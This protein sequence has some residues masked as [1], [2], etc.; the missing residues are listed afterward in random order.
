[1]PH[2][3]WASKKIGDIPVANLGLILAL[4]II[5]PLV[6]PSNYWIRIAGNAGLW[7]MLALGLNVVAGF[8][9]LLDLGYVA[10]YAVGGYLYALLSSGHWNIH[11]PFLLVLPICGLVASGF[12]WAL[13][14]TSMRVRGDYLA[15]VTLA[16][17]QIMRLLLL[18]LDRPVNITGGPNGLVDLDYA[19][20][21]GF[22]FRTVTQ[23]YYLIISM[24]LLVV[25]ASYRLKRSRLG[26]GW[27]AIR[28]DE[29]AANAMGVNVTYMKLLAFGIGAGIAGGA[30]AVFASWQGGV[31]PNNFD[32][33]QLVT[34]YCM[35]ILGGVGNIWGVILA[36][37]ILSILP[38]AL[39][40]YGAYRMI[41]YGLLLVILMAV[42]PQGLLGEIT[43]FS[44]RRK[45]EKGEEVGELKSAEELFYGEGSR[46]FVKP[47][48]KGGLDRDRVLL[49]LKDLTMDFGGLRAV[50]ML[51]LEVR[52]GEIVSIIGPNGAG[53]TTV[54]NLITGIY[55]PTS[56]A[57]LFEGEDITGKK[58]HQI[59]RMGIGRTFQ[60]LRLFN[61][62]TVLENAMV[63]QHCRSSSS[64][65]SVL[66]RTPGFLREEERIERIAKENLGLFGARLTGFRYNQKAMNLSYANRRRMEMARALSTDSKLVLLDEPSA[67]MNPKETEEITRFIRQ[68]RDDYGCS[69]L[70]IEHKLKVVKTISDRVIVL[71][72]GSKIA[73]GEYDDVA[74]NE[75]VIQ[76]YLGRKHGKRAR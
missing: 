50:N 66:V 38:E 1:M 34:V 26:R 36:A 8:A 14:S 17:A 63:A 57:I 37:I 61:N 22:T 19:G 45:K 48:R 7:I 13:G 30:G 41:G 62:M 11:L 16:F 31:F 69:F 71:D 10:F 68:L 25:L 12:G 43:L 49:E 28:E 40:E 9:G 39:R 2:F 21:F 33:P 53:K 27:E 72:Y 35:L 46:D 5:V 29:L 3:D 32:F 51:S 6:M 60:T 58:P 15:I 4:V 55:P 67:G 59:V 47:L 44:F 20:I 54:F 70:I 73:E 64:L 74:N 65:F 75:H 24:A 56:G 52:E 42:R 76:A 23:Y 18:N